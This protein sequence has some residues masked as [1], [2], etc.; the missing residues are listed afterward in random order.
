LLAVNYTE[1]L[2]VCSD[3]SRQ[4]TPM[5]IVQQCNQL[6]AFYLKLALAWLLQNNFLIHTGSAAGEYRHLDAQPT[7]SILQGPSFNRR[8][9]IW[10]ILATRNRTGC[11][12]NFQF[13]QLSMPWNQ[14]SLTQ[15]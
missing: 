4:P 1:E 12:N 10:F 13:K 7:I 14:D 3:G 9:A 5:L 8:G 2:Q 11:I 15:L 6:R